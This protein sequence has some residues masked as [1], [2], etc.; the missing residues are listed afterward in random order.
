MLT[1]I[2][3]PT[4]IYAKLSLAIL[5]V[6]CAVGH[7]RSASLFRELRPGKSTKDGKSDAKS[8]AETKDSAK[9]KSVAKTDKSKKSTKKKTLKKKRTGARPTRS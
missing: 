8:S 3:I 9:M 2:A 4:M 6:L 5:F 1:K 7:S